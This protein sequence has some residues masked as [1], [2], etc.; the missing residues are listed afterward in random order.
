M[1]PDAADPDY[2]AFIARGL[3]KANDPHQRR[4]SKSTIT[5]S[6]LLRQAAVLDSLAYICVS[7]AEKQVIAIGV[8][9]LPTP[10]PSIRIHVAEN[11]FPLPDVVS[12]LQDV[13]SRLH[14][15][16]ALQPPLEAH[17]KGSP[18]IPPYIAGPSTDFER[19]LV[20]LECVIIKH[21]WAKTRQRAMNGSRSI[22]FL[23]TLADVIGLP[24]HERLNDLDEHE[25][26]LLGKLQAGRQAMDVGLFE[27]LERCIRTVIHILG[28]EATVER[29]GAL[30]PFLAGLLNVKR[31]LAGQEVFFQVWNEYTYSRLENQG[32]KLKKYPDAFKWLSKVVSIREHYIRISGIVT[33]KSLASVFLRGVDIKPVE[34]RGPSPTV[35][36]VDTE[37]LGKVLVAAGCEDDTSGEFAESLR[38]AQGGVRITDNKWE[39][40]ISPCIHCEC[41]VLAKLHGHPAIPYIGVSKSSCAFCDIYFAAYREATESTFCT[42]GGRSQTSKWKVPEIADSSLDQEVRN[43]VC[44]KLLAKIK[45]GWFEH[46]RASLASQSKTASGDDAPWQQHGAQK[47]AILEEMNTVDLKAVMKE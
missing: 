5:D 15:I 7:K 37:T 31:E 44:A 38:A 34:H 8:E 39:L 25:R 23:N 14:Q 41:A 1:E 35:M 17:G 21:S 18:K 29:A 47:A 12:H 42:R 22:N 30:R 10:G 43:R 6:L 16:H 46:N 40:T 26:T 36:S 24:S 13:F 45:K 33:S 4:E 27:L 3:D 2:L 11:R 32:V 9:S 19:G 28:A 20:D